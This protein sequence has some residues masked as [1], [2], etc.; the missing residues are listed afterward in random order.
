M[1][2]VPHA[3]RLALLAAVVTLF[4]GAF[5]ARSQPVENPVY[6]D[7]SPVAHDTLGRVPTLVQ[8]GNFPEAVRALQRLLETESARVIPDAQDPDLFVSVR[9]SVHDALLSDDELIDRYRQMQGPPAQRSLDEGRLALVEDQ[10]LLTE[11]GLEAALRVAQQHIESARFDAAALA[12]L[13]LERHPDRS[14]STDAAQLLA[15]ASRYLDSPALRERAQRWWNEAGGRGRLDLDPAPW[16]EG[17]TERVIGLDGSHPPIDLDAVPAQALQ[18][19]MYKPAEAARAGD[20][21]EGPGLYPHVIPT[22]VGDMVYLSDGGFISA[23]DRFTLRPLWRVQPPAELAVD[24]TD[25]AQAGAAVI[26]PS[27]R[28][29]RIEDANT[30]T[31]AGPLLVTTTGV[32]Y[33]GGRS[34]DPR[35]HAI[36]RRTGRIVWSVLLPTLDP[37]LRYASVRGTLQVDGDTVV[38]GVRRF[39]QA[40]RLMSVYLVGLDLSTG[41][42]KWSRLIGSAGS[43]PYQDL[44]RLS[45]DSTLHKG[46]VYRADPIGLIAAVEAA[47]GRPLWIRRTS[48]ARVGRNE[49]LRAWAVNRPVVVDGDLVLLSPDREDILR[50]DLETGRRSGDPVP[51][52]KYDTPHFLLRVGD[53]LAGV[54]I[55]R[56]VFAEIGDGTIGRPMRSSYIPEPG[57]VGRPSVA[58]DMLLVPTSDGLLRFDPEHPDTP[59]VFPIESG[60]NLLA[61]PSQLLVADDTRLHSHLVWGEAAELLRSRMQA[62]PDDPTHALTLAVLAYRSAHPEHIVDAVDAALEIIEA[63]PLEPGSIEARRALSDALATM[64][65]TSQ[66]A[67]DGPEASGGSDPIIAQA[68]IVGELVDR[69]GR[70]G[71]TSADQAAYLLALGR[72][73]SAEGEAAQ[74]VRAYQRLLD[75]PGLGGEMWFGPRGAVRAELEATRRLRGVL[76]RFGPDAY[77]LFDRELTGETAFLGEEAPGEELESLARRYPVARE[78]PRVWMGAARAY[79]DEGDR[80]ATVRALRSAMIAVEFNAR[81]GR[82]PDREERAEIA[83]RL[84]TA[85]AENGRFNEA[86]RVLRE[87]RAADPDLVLSYAGERLDPS[88]LESELEQ[89][90]AQRRRR[91]IIGREISPEPQLLVGWRLA[92]SL[93]TDAPVTD[94]VAMISLTNGELGMFAPSPSTGALERLWSVSFEG[95]SPMVIRHDDD[96]IYLLHESD[97][98]VW[99]ECLA[100]LDGQRRWRTEPF[101]TLFPNREAAELRLF[102]VEGRPREIITPLDGEVDLTATLIAID[103]RTLLVVERS[104]R[105]G[106][107]DLD[108]GDALWKRTTVLSEV[109]DAAAGSG[110]LALGGVRQRAIDG[111][112]QTVLPVPIIATFDARS[113]EALNETEA[114]EGDVRWMRVTPLGELIVGAEGGT[115]SMN[116][117]DG[118]VNWNADRPELRGVDRRLARRRTHLRPRARPERLRGP[119][120]ERALRRRAGRVT[121]PARRTL[122]HPRLRPGLQ[123]RLRQRTGRHRPRPERLAR[124]ARRARRVRDPAPRRR[125]RGVVR[126]DRDGRA[127]P[128]RDRLPA[129]PAVHADR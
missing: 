31:V 54:T 89:R 3:P 28:D 75:D 17:A 33:N 11:A 92:G 47:T 124:R 10:W 65:Q 42:L 96:S 9:D 122:D 46:V 4:L 52:S 36:D 49:Q 95:A 13:Q 116:L 99:L 32:A 21:D 119:L 39:V 102:D 18:S 8:S 1:D 80:H 55:N 56:V 40:R 101:R 15:L 61:L 109:Y 98:G 97:E 60:G 127:R 120:R 129:L 74:S 19:A 44:Q 22:V 5:S 16:P 62:S 91:P 70:T 115:T 25:P 68:D 63:S 106:A 71:E 26:R 73:R 78:A 94:R 58:G 88:E 87:L 82:A 37:Q 64:V 111:E 121:R 86:A 20:D 103:E 72:Q 12:L 30:V 108:T 81:I 110:V 90:L 29:S 128:R 76:E 24:M 27:R 69:M 123:H 50:L 53:Y 45:T 114:I 117:I 43:L 57:I 38:V 125:R 100:S 85:L 66:D 77:A 118:R 35:V 126:H 41:D 112:G 23:W 51:G 67:W 107:F 83:G 7:D 48:P 2:R 34:G 84:I 59:E 113:G 105:I 104:G 79:E 93:L 6:V 14:R